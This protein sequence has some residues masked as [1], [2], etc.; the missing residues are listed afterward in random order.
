MGEWRVNCRDLPR[1]VTRG[2][3]LGRREFPGA[4]KAR[5]RLCCAPSIATC[6]ARCRSDAACSLWIPLLRAVA[7][8][9]LRAF[10]PP[11][12][13]RQLSP[14]ALR[15]PSQS[16]LRHPRLALSPSFQMPGTVLH[17]APLANSRQSQPTHL[18]AADDAHDA[19]ALVLAHHG[20]RCRC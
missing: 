2:F 14:N 20:C 12:T 8:H 17:P 6:V 5:R 10:L 4:K 13:H 19:N 18:G 3:F 7:R 15:F 9:S 1:F 16:A 11:G